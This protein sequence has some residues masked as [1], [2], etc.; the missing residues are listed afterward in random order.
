MF[1]STVNLNIA[2]H[3]T[4]H[5]FYRYQHYGERDNGTACAE[6]FRNEVL[7]PKLREARRNN[8]RIVVDFAGLMGCTAAFLHEVFGGLFYTGEWTAAELDE[9]IKFAPEKSYYAPYISNAHGF[10][11]GRYTDCP[12][13]FDNLRDQVIGGRFR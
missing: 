7:I 4:E 1:K 6:I 3:V 2:Q 12:E 11:T 8:Y 5:A 10:L 13:P 9:T